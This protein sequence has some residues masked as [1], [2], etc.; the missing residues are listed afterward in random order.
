[1]FVQY[2]NQFE[3]TCCR[4]DCTTHCLMA[5]EDSSEHFSMNI[6]KELH[7]F[8]RITKWKL[9]QLAQSPLEWYIISNVCNKHES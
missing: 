4:N 1:M 9:F 7:T 3:S 5:L 2:L 6:N 8:I